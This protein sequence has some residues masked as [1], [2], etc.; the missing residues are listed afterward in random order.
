MKNP[1]ERAVEAT[2]M[3]YRRFIRSWGAEIEAI[4]N[5]IQSLPPG[6]WV[7]ISCMA[8]LLAATMVFGLHL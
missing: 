2:R 1:L 4:Y 3:E 7:V 6:I 8:L 5:D